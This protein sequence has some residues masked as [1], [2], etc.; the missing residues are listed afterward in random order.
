MIT[1]DVGCMLQES[2]GEK[3]YHVTDG[4]LFV[5]V[6]TGNSNNGNAILAHISHFSLQFANE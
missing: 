2:N 6:R 3:L 4:T 1:F 5:V